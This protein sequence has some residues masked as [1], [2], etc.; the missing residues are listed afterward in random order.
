MAV[1]A[2]INQIEGSNRFHLP[3][4]SEKQT[5]LGGPAG[6]P[7]GQRNSRDGFVDGNRRGFFDAAGIGWILR[8]RKRRGCSWISGK[9]AHG[10]RGAVNHRAHLR[11]R[12]PLIF[13]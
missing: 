4:E 8:P 5:A 7:F 9:S 10:G 12:P 13:P 1:A 2:V 11:G 6:G 3:R